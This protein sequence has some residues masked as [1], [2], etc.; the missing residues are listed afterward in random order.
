VPD[1]YRNVLSVGKVT[2]LGHVA[3]FDKTSCIVITRDRPFRIIA[4]GKHAPGSGVYKLTQLAQ[5]LDHN[6]QQVHSL[7]S[8]TK[9][10][11]NPPQNNSTVESLS[12]LWH[13][14][15]GHTSFSNLRL[16]TS[17]GLAIGIPKFNVV[18]HTCTT[19]HEGKQTREHIPHKSDT[20]ATTPLGLIHTDLCGPL[21][22]SS[23]ARTE[24]FILFTDDYSQKS[25][26]YFLKTKDQASEKFKQFYTTV[27]RQ[28][29]Q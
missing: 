26:I 3:V 29:G 21:P 24:Y 16:V 27:E 5:D 20:R 10:N 9:T 7:D 1:L 28:T 22:V 8:I 23:L 2:D 19:C 17:H 18:Q 11:Q 6:P 15:L 14:R 25:W 13:L 4:Q 12:R